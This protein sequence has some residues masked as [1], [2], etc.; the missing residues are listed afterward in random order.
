MA[1]EP[2]E[3]NA[4]LAQVRPAGLERRG[5]ENPSDHVFEPS[6]VPPHPLDQ[7]VEPRR[8]GAAQR[9]RLRGEL[10]TGD[11][12][13]ELVGDGGDE[14]LLPAA[15]LRLFAQRAADDRD[16]AAQHDEKEGALPQ[17]LAQ[18]PHVLALDL[19]E[20]PRR[21]GDLRGRDVEGG[22]ER[23][24][25]LRRSSLGEQSLRRLT[26]GVVQRRD[27]RRLQVHQAALI[28][29]PPDDFTGGEDQDRDEGDPQRALAIGAQRHRPAGVPGCPSTTWA[30]APARRSRSSG[31]WASDRKPTS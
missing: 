4:L 31:R 18:A 24:D 25:A 7:C 20:S 14:V 5:V 30:S 21:D 29:H 13:L 23:R 11:R 27:A 8:L 26:V 6:D 2:R 15:Q 17:V 1:D 28:D 3:R 16:T 19:G 12:A 10:Q 22:K 9:D